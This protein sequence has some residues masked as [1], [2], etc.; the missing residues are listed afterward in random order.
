MARRY[1]WLFC[2]LTPLHI[3]NATSGSVAAYSN[4]FDEAVKILFARFADISDGCKMAEVLGIASAVLGLLPLAVEVVKGFHTLC[5]AIKAS[6]ACTKKLVALDVD[7]Q[8]QKAIFINECEHILGM[9]S[10]SSHDPRMM[11]QDP[12]HPLWC[13]GA[14]E[15]RVK[16]CMAQ[17]YEQCIHIIKAMRDCQQELASGLEL[18]TIIRRERSSEESL[19]MTFL[20]LRKS[21]M[22]SLDTSRY[23]RKLD[24]IRQHNMS[25]SMIRSQIKEFQERQAKEPR[26][27]LPAKNSLPSWISTV[28][29]LSKDAYTTLTSAFSCQVDG[30]IDH[31]AALRAEDTGIPRGS[32]HLNVGL[33]YCLSKA[34]EPQHVLPFSLE[35]FAPHEDWQPVSPSQR[36][37][38]R[39]SQEPSK[40]SSNYQHTQIMT[41]QES[42]VTNLSKV[43]NACAYLETSFSSQSPTDHSYLAYIYE[44]ALCHHSFYVTADRKGALRYSGTL[45]NVMLDTGSGSMPITDQYKL[46][47]K[48]TMAMLQFHSTPW[49]RERWNTSDLLLGT[50]DYTQRASRADLFLR[51][52]FFSQ[53]ADNDVD[54]S[55]TPEVIIWDTKGKEGRRHT[56]NLGVA[57]LEID[58]WAPLSQIRLDNDPD[59]VATA[60][61]AAQQ[62]T[63][64]G[65]CYGDIVQRCLKCHFGSGHDLSKVELQ[66]AIYTNVVC[67]L[68]HLVEALD[69]KV[70]DGFRNRSV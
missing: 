56:E 60:M 38:V 63:V 8:T 13:D 66:S 25:I 58:R 20:K 41:A 64:L 45:S 43:E 48:V 59:D 54:P 53:T 4:S 26:L 6:R 21:L 46:A 2:A 10:S 3:F 37:R 51:S 35:A 18:F 44:A 49:L 12:D 7:L 34:Y 9:V 39:F 55:K 32:V 30:H 65:K 11:T 52:R 57:L 23:E 61:R 36:R 67:P 24:K 47:I 27:K 1:D 31:F 5:H 15:S 33:A 22:F 14:L 19:R 50:L 62:I 69:G 17:S 16:A 29:E 28:H 40:D 42:Q 70:D 68:Q